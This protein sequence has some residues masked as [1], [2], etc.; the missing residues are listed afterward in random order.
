MNHLFSQL[1]RRET[2]GVV[3]GAGLLL[4]LLGYLLIGRPLLQRL[5]AYTNEIPAQRQLLTWIEQASLEVKR[6]RAVRQGTPGEAGAAST[7]SLINKSAKELQLDRSIK[8][9]EP[10]ADKGV[11]VWLDEAS[12]DGMIP[13]L[14]LLRERQGLTVTDISVERGKGVGKVNALITFSAGPP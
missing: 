4:I 6:V 2:V 3:T 14:A 11:R 5:D 12:F 1:S 7:L 8:R 10:T 13:W 9:V